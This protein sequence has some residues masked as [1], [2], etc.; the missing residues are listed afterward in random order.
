[1]LPII[2]NARIASE[3]GALLQRLDS[4]IP[5]HARTVSRLSGGQRQAVSIARAL[6]WQ[7][8]VLIMDE[9]TAALTVMQREHLTALARRLASEGVI[10]MGPNLPL[11]SKVRF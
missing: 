8:K 4:R 9:P 11:D 1:M 10:Y 6:Y 3:I 2:D 7:A 5:R